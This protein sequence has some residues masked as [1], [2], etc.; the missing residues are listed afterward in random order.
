MDSSTVW[1]EV[2]AA[3]DRRDFDAA[4]RLIFEQFA[5]RVLNLIRAKLGRKLSQHVDAEDV[6]NDVWISY[7]RR[8]ERVILDNKA[9]FLAYL[10]TMAVR[11]IA[12]QC[13]E[14]RATA[15]CE[16]LDSQIGYAKLPNREGIV[17][18]RNYVSAP[19]PE[20]QPNSAFQPGLFPDT[21]CTDDELALMCC[22]LHL[23][24][25]GSAVDAEESLIVQDMVESLPEEARQIVLKK[26]EGFSNAEIAA[27]RRCS[28]RTVDRWVKAIKDVWDKYQRAS[29]NA[30]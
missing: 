11:K 25:K 18:I 13:R 20:S 28:T 15:V 24:G 17:P 19:E 7:L 26:L 23:R 8:H 21:F 1:D 14:N 6:A 29:D 12:R 5:N 9:S 27:Q 4:N 30:M 10:L 16:E 2:V 22:G 3:R